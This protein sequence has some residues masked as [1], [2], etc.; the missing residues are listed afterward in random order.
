MA[1]EQRLRWPKF[2]SRF[3]ELFEKS[4]NAS[5]VDRGKV[6]ETAVLIPTMAARNSGAILRAKMRAQKGRVEA[7]I[8][9]WGVLDFTYISHL[10]LLS[11]Q[12]H[13]TGGF[14]PDPW[15]VLSR[16]THIL[17]FSQN[18]PGGVDP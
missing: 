15:Q 2:L 4:T 12:A 5:K 17:D 8:E 9:K 14:F 3:S 16:T 7:P 18:L 6:A 13:I 1:Q 11:P 10:K